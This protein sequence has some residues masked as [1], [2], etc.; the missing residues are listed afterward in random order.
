MAI[1]HLTLIQV[2]YHGFASPLCTDH[3]SA[4]H[5]GYD[6]II[7]GP[8]ALS[9]IL[10]TAN[11]LLDDNGWVKGADGVRA[12]GGQRLEFEYSRSSFQFCR[13]DVEAIIQRNLRAIGIKLDIQNYPYDKFFGSFLPE[14]KASP[15]T[16]AV[17]GRYDIAEFEHFGYDPDNSSLLSCDQIPPNG[18]NINFY[19]NHALD[20]LY[21][22]G[23]GDSG[24]RRATA[25]LHPDPSDLP[26]GVPSHRALQPNRISRWCARGRTTTSP[27]LL[28][29]RPQHLGVVVR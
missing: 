2:A 1:N 5:P 3:G 4:Y 7:V 17:A 25:G 16:G 19:C 24:S 10:A 27:A 15:P 23:T 9:L 26:D 12:K 20:D 11:K 28:T 21:T 13:L 22:T 8:T 29:E 18:G 6:P 14:G